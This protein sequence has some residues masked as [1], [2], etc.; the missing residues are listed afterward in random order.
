LVAHLTIPGYT[1]AV[2]VPCQYLIYS[3]IKHNL[4]WKSPR[5]YFCQINIGIVQC[6]VYTSVKRNNKTHILFLTSNSV[7]TE[8]KIGEA[9]L[10]HYIGNKFGNFLLQGSQQFVSIKYLIDTKQLKNRYN[11]KPKF[12]KIRYRICR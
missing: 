1:C 2:A 11:L 3:S 8:K 7:T 9:P 4:W 12:W 5:K 6:A 10:S